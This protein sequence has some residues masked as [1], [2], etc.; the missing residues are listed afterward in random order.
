MIP[1]KLTLHFSIIFLV[2]LSTNVTAQKQKVPPGGRLAVVVD[3]RLSAL[4]ATTDLTGKLVRRVIS[5]SAN[6]P[7]CAA[8]VEPA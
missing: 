5:P 7:C 4:R 8:V 6:E 2:L 1:H 3:E